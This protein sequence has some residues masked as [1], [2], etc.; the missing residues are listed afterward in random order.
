MA[1]G[2]EGTQNMSQDELNCLKNLLQ[3]M[4]CDG[5]VSSRE[6]QF[7]K[8]AADSL[9][10]EVSDWNALLK[11]VVGDKQAVYPLANRNKALAALKAMA[12]MAKADDQV[13]EKEKTVLQT[14]AKTIGLTKE[15]WKQMLSELDL[16]TVFEPFGKCLGTMTVL[17]DDFEKIDAFLKIAGENNVQTRILTCAEYLKLPAA[18][19]DIVCF[20]AAEDRERTVN[21][22]ALLLKKGGSRPVCILTRFQGHQVKYLHEAGLEKC[23]IEPVY[24]RDIVELFK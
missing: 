14:F 17:K 4:C 2:T 10:V 7:L 1:H 8:F 13:N 21:I 6:K 20:H 22:S 16:S 15:Q 12:L 18:T 23:I 19:D 9:K 11:E 3:V 24:T 5:E